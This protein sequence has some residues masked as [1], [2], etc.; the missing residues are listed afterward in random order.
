[1]L[2]PAGSVPAV[3]SELK[4]THGLLQLKSERQD[5]TKDLKAI[6]CHKLGYID[7]KTKIC[8]T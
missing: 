8:V 3:E 5:K 4:V 7:K 6:N 2:A 1:M